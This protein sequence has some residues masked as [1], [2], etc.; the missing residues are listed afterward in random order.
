[1][2][3]TSGQ[4]ETAPSALPKRLEVYDGCTVEES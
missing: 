1:M 4:H 2:D 3:D